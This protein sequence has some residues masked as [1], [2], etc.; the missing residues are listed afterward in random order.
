MP[1]VPDSSRSSLQQKLTG[2][3]RERWPQLSSVDVTHPTPYAYVTGIL[4][5][6]Q[7]PPLFRLRYG[8]SASSWGFSIYRASLCAFVS[9]REIIFPLLVSLCASLSLA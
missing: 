5:D 9:L 8:G 4:T 1:K 3:A 6:G 7:Q 2:R